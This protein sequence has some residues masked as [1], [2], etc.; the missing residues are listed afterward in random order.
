[1]AKSKIPRKMADPEVRFWSSVEFHDPDQCWPWTGALKNDGR[2]AFRMGRRGEPS[3]STGRAAF[4]FAHGHLP[5]QANHLPV[6]CHDPGCCNPL[7][8]YDGTQTDNMQDRLSD[9]YRHRRLPSEVEAAVAAEVNRG[10]SQVNVAL[11]YGLDK[12]LINR[13]MRAARG[14][15]YTQPRRRPDADHE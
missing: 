9:G 10:A 3:I 13:V 2:G 14:I 15:P 1:M 7:H 11:A 4:L 5:I 8:I 6:D 12:S